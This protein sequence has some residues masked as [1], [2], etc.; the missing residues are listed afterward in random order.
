LL[1]LYT[2][3][4]GK[5]TQKWGEQFFNDKQIYTNEEIAHKKIIGCTKNSEI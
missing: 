1:I 3:L 2:L 5:E 4:R